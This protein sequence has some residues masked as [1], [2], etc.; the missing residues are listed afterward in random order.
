MP[1]TKLVQLKFDQATKA[2]LDAVARFKGIPLTSFI[3]LVLTQEVRREKKNMLTE[4]GLNHEEENEVLRREKEFISES[5]K[6][7]VKK[8]MSVKQLFNE[9]DA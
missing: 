7:K 2:D 1:A 3:K 8:G 5:K 9:L 4:N 6:H